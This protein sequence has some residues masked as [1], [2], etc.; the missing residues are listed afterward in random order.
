[1]ILI[2]DSGEWSRI[3]LINS[4]P[5]S[6]NPTTLSTWTQPS[7]LTRTN[8]TRNAGSAQQNEVNTSPD[9]SSLSPKEADNV[10]ES[11]K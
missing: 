5:R 1:M 8:S 4:R 6:A 10:S 7:S 2:V 9:S 11:S 3:I